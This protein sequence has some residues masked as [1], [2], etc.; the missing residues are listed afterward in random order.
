M[1]KDKT[2]TTTLTFTTHEIQ[3]D[4]E[5]LKSFVKASCQTYTSLERGL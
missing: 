1:C 5:E 4:K 3:R 2:L